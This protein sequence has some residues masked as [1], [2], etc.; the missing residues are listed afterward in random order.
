VLPCKLGKSSALRER[1]V[2]YVRGFPLAAYKYT[3]LGSVISTYDRDDYKE[4]D[5]DDFVIDARLSQGNSGS[6]VLA[7]SCATGEYELVGIY[8]A[9]YSRGSSLNVVIQ[10]DQARDFLTL[11]KK[12]VATRPDAPSGSLVMDDRKRL[13]EA[14]NST[15]VFFPFGTYSASVRAKEGRLVFEIYP[16]NFPTESWPALV[17]EDVAT[18]APNEFGDLGRVFFGNARGLKE[19]ERVRMSAEMHAQLE[20][21]LEILRRAALA[22]VEYRRAAMLADD[23]KDAFDRSKRLEK[24]LR[25]AGTSSREIVT[26]V[27]ELMER[28]SPKPGER[29]DFP[30]RTAE[31]PVDAGLE[32][33]IQ[34]LAMPERA[35]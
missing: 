23:S 1:S 6:P 30:A 29:L 9:G 33:A 11:L 10:I 17:I 8:H 34:L 7:V 2:V 18:G 22:A 5:H 16:R 4:W 26:A 27:T 21:S 20:R 15:G 25:R 32:R 19:Q 13:A 28:E 31:P 24:A 14:S 3:I 35:Q 12:S